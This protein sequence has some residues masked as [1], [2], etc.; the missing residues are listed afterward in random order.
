VS[1][2]GGWVTRADLRR[3]AWIVAVLAVVGALLGVVWQVWSPHGPQGFVIAAH[4][5]QP[6]ETEAFVAADGRFALIS[7]ITGVIA[8]VVVW[9]V[10]SARGPVSVAALALGGLVGSWLTESVGHVLA[11]GHASGQVNTVIAHLPLSVHMTG[12]RVLEAAVA[13]L[14]CGLLV[15]FAADDDLGRPGPAGSVG[16]GDQLQDGRRNGDAAGALQQPYLPPQ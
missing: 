14:T 3:G 9:N 6:D 16:L 13:V 1:A 8:A 5:V 10:R 7:A 11:G 2:P 15:S 12:L 4:A